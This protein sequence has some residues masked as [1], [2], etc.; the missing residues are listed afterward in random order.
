[1]SP[2]SGDDVTLTPHTSPLPSNGR[3][4]IVREI[5]QSQ[6]LQCVTCYSTPST[7]PGPRP[8][9]SQGSWS[10]WVGFTICYWGITYS[11]KTFLLILLLS[12]LEGGSIAQKLGV[13]LEPITSAEP[14]KGSGPQFLLEWGQL[15][16]AIWAFGSWKF[17]FIFC[18]LGYLNCPY[19]LRFIGKIS[20]TAQL[21]W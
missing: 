8:L 3:P 2:A 1:M 13:A 11:L 10:Y 16:R 14:G 7:L 12:P 6:L 18:S 9:S 4:T 20:L 17:S 5:R 21:S 15:S 19:G